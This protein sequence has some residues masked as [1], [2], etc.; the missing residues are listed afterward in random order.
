MCVFFIFSLFLVSLAL[1]VDI[2]IVKRRRPR[3]VGGAIEISLIDW[4]ST[5]IYEVDARCFQYTRRSKFVDNTRHSTSRRKARDW[6]KIAFLIF[7]NPV[8]I[9]P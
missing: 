2:Y 4:P 8:G 9:L 6:L 7:R 1:Y 3:F 5:D